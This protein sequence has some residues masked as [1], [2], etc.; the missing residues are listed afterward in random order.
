MNGDKPV[1]MTGITVEANNTASIGG[2]YTPL[3]SRRLGLARKAV[4]LHM[5][6]I[7]NRGMTK[8]VLS[9]ANTAAARA[10]EAIGFSHIGT[11]SLVLF[12]NSVQVKS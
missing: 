10:Y 4:A 9:A 2:V 7:R 1:A 3:A 8:A 6:E 12:H 5:A 11:Y